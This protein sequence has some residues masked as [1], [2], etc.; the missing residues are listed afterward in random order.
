MK[1]QQHLFKCQTKK[2]IQFQFEKITD[3]SGVMPLD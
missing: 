2:T 1:R 3:K